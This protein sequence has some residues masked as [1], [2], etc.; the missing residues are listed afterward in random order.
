MIKVGI[1]GSSGYTGGEF[2]RILAGHP[3]AEVTY[4][5]SHTYAGS[6]VGDVLPAFAHTPWVFAPVDIDQ[7][8]AQCD[9]IIAAVPA[10]VAMELAPAV[11][12]AG[13]KFIDIGTDFRFH[14]TQLYKKWYGI[15]HSCPD[16]LPKAVYGLPEL[17]RD[18]IKGADLIGN[19]GCYPT[20]ILLGMAPALKADIIDPKDVV[21]ASMSGVSGAGRKP[22][23]TNHFPERTENLCPY[24]VASHRHTPEIE[25][26]AGLYGKTEVQVSFTPHLVPMSRG[27]LSTLVLKLRSAMAEDAVRE[28]YEEHYRGEEFV[29]VLPP[30]AL[31]QTKA[32]AGSNY[33]HL[34]VRVDERLGRL[35]VMVAIDNLGKGAAGQA[36][37]NMNLMFGLDEGMG[38]RTVGLYP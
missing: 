6:R 29:C 2:L 34:A 25:V 12:A 23:V 3:E 18:Q 32:V 28:L 30:P 5:A 9:C 20:S 22:T 14:D 17:F 15:D 13:K 7:M 21:V 24:G 27:I 16:L 33:A 37:Q 4:L 35:L 31:P 1:I 10:G 8:A 36:I 38:L 11:L 19:P 26:Q